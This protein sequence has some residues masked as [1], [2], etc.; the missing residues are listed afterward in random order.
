MAK[1]I[2]AATSRI[3]ATACVL[4]SCCCVGE[5]SGA[6][7][8]PLACSVRGKQMAGNGER[9]HGLDCSRIFPDFLFRDYCI[10][11]GTLTCECQ[12]GQWTNCEES[13][14]RAGDGIELS[15]QPEPTTPA[16]AAKQTTP[17]TTD[18]GNNPYNQPTTPAATPKRTIPAEYAADE[19]T[20]DFGGTTMK[21]G[22]A[23]MSDTDE[24]VCQSNGQMRCER[25][26]G[27]CTFGGLPTPNGA[28]RIM[29]WATGLEQC[30]CASGKWICS[31]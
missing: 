18:Q 16:P 22:E 12:A 29:R 26:P 4:L 25:L 13:S 5:V 23:Y 8:V 20:C 14:V 2:R 21:L 24:C 30:K 11:K 10:G 6:R 31:S 3:L 17:A 1:F 7:L 15:T 19:T 28:K 9:A 27:W